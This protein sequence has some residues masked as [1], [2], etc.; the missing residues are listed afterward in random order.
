MSDIS[1]VQLAIVARQVHTN[2]RAIEA[3]AEAERP[4]LRTVAQIISGTVDLINDWLPIHIRRR[5]AAGDMSIQEIWEQVEPHVSY[6]AKFTTTHQ[7]NPSQAEPLAKMVRNRLIAIGIITYGILICD[8]IRRALHGDL[9][10]PIIAIDGPTREYCPTT[11]VEEA[12]MAVKIHFISDRLVRDLRDIASNLEAINEQ[13]STDTRFNAADVALLIG[14]I[15]NL[16]ANHIT[17][18]ILSSPPGNMTSANWIKMS[19]TDHLKRVNEI[20]KVILNQPSD[21]LEKHKLDVQTTKL[22]VSL[23]VTFREI[24]LAPDIQSALASQESVST[25]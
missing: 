1:L 2:L 9:S 24:Y 20:F 7:I 19:A 12:I 11:Q 3:Q 4:D 10:R 15:L 16:T 22:L 23:F 14:P 17:L 21:E 8:N 13:V 25:P 5:E 18:P 6:L